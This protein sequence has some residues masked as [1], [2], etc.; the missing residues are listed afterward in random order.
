VNKSFGKLY[1]K[2]FTGSLFG[3]GPRV[4]SVWAYCIANAM[5]PLGTVEL[6]VKLLAPMLGMPEEEVKGGID[7]LCSPD[8]ASRTPT[9]E[10]RRL[11][12]VSAFEYRL[13]NFEAHRNGTD[14]EARRETW[15]KSQ[16]KHREAASND[17]KPDVNTGQHKQKA[18]A[19]G[20]SRRQK[21]RSCVVPR[22][23][24]SQ[25]SNVGQTD[26]ATGVA[27]TSQTDEQWIAGL[28]TS[29]AY[30]GIDVIA[31]HAK[32]V[33][34]CNENHRQATRRRF[35]NW[36]NRCDKPTGHNPTPTPAQVPVHTKSESFNTI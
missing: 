15:R 13:V 4:F 32:M 17:V 30:K 29:P 20:R 18:E 2:T 23:D 16:K 34:W 19:E 6:N 26:C 28:K 3:A 25:R 5:P 24:L 22:S 1:A 27:P 35:V 11:R 9:D 10:G 21:A 33:Y 12:H 14:I 31:E 7:Y 8:P 36:L